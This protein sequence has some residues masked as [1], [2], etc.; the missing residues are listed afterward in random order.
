MLALVAFALFVVVVAFAALRGD[1][2][3]ARTALEDQ[4]VATQHVDEGS[5]VIEVLPTPPGEAGREAVAEPSEPSSATTSGQAGTSSGAT[6]VFRFVDTAERELVLP[7]VEI[8]GSR[9]PSISSGNVTT[10]EDVKRNLADASH[11]VVEN[12]ATGKWQWTFKTDAREPVTISIEHVRADER[13]ERSVTFGPPLRDVHVSLVDE[14][15]APISVTPDA[16]GPL[17]GAHVLPQLVERSVAI[18]DPLPHDAHPVKQRASRLPG[19]DSF[20]IRG[21]SMPC[22]VAL[23]HG[24]RVVDCVAV[25]EG[26]DRVVMRL[27][28]ALLVRTFGAV[29]L[30]VVDASSGVPVAG[31]DVEIT[32]AHALPRAIVT[33]DVD[34][35]ARVERVPVGALKAELRAKGYVKKQAKGVATAD[36]ACQLGEIVLVPLRRVTGSVAG[37]GAGEKAIV[38]AFDF[39]KGRRKSFSIEAEAT[40]NGSTFELDGLPAGRYFLATAPPLGDVEIEDWIGDR[41]QTV[42]VDV[43]HGSLGGVV[44]PWVPASTLSGMHPPR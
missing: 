33:T 7:K 6:F 8:R 5:N 9:A 15:G 18:G 32:P 3:D 4:R 41:S 24:E 43:T 44:V 1:R 26:D 42:E 27:P 28:R 13:I 14:R 34:G 38:A 37:L 36:V 23:M 19:G 29:E 10:F 31:V 22:Y 17:G 39:T 30:R 25:A 20:S 16:D 2:D 11:C 40:T 21:A 35:R 12:V